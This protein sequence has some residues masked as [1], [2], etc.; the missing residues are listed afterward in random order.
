M[1]K[2]L[3]CRIKILPEAVLRNT[4]SLLNYSTKVEAILNFYQDI[5]N[6]LY[7]KLYLQW[8]ILIKDHDVMFW[9]GCGWQQNAMRPPLP[10][11]GCGGEW[12]ETGRNWWVGRRAV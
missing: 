2:K 11:L 3:F 1:I 5:A 12:K 6:Q 10:L 8:Q 4:K 9:F 7:R